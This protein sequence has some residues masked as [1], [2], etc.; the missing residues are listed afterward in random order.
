MVNIIR[1]SPFFAFLLLLILSTTTNTYAA[2]GAI[3]RTWDGSSSSKW[4][5]NNNWSGNNFPNS[6]AE[7]AIIVAA[8]RRP[9][10]NANI[11]VGCVEVQS[12]DMRSSNNRTFT[13]QGDYFRA[14]G[15]AS[16]FVSTNHNWTIHLAGSSHQDLDIVDPV[17]NLTI[18]NST[19]VSFN[20]PF[21]VRNTFTMSGTGTYLNVNEDLTL[22]DSA[23]TVTIPSA[24]TIEVA[25]GKTLNIFGSLVVNGTLILNPG[26]TLML[27]NAKSLTVGASGQLR[28]QGSSGNV[29]TVKSQ[30]GSIDAVLNGSLWA[31]YFRFSSF[32]LTTAGIKING[33][34]AMLEFGEFHFIPSGGY[35]LTLGSTVN[36][37]TTANGI[38]FYDDNAYG[39]TKSINASSY[40]STAMM[41]NDWSGNGGTPS[42]TDPN[43]KIDWGVQ[44]GTTLTLSN[45][46]NIGFPSDPVTAGSAAQEFAIFAFALSQNSA[47]TDITQVTFTLN[48][49]ATASDIDYVQVFNQGASCQVRGAQIGG[50]INMSGFPATATINIPSATVTTSGTTPACIHVLVRTTATAENNATIGIKIDGTS[51]VVNSQ[52]Y[53][54]SGVSGPPVSGPVVTISGDPTRLWRGSNSTN[55]RTNGNWQGGWPGF[56]EN[57]KIQAGV[58]TVRL[59]ANEACQNTTLVSTGEINWNNSSFSLTVWGYL[60]VEAGFTYTNAANSSLIMGGATNQSMV[61]SEPFPGNVTINNT[62]GITS[63]ISVDGDSTI[64]GNLTVTNGLLRIASGVTLQVNGSVTVQTG[65]KLDIEPGGTL[66]MANGRVVTINTG[67]TLEMV[68]GATDAIM[69]STGGTAAF[70]VVVNGTIKASHYLFDHLGV[71]GVTINAG[72]AIDATD[73]LSF[74]TFKHPVNNSSTLLTLNLQ[75]PGNTLSTMAFDLNGSAA[76]AATI[77]NIKT[78]TTVG[79]LTI[80]SYSGNLSGPTYENAPVYLINWTGLTN[81]LDIAQ[82]ATSST[83]VYQGQTYNMGRFSL[84]QSQAGASYVNTNINSIA[85]TLTG[86]G[87]SNDISVARLYYD[88]NCD[89]SG[90]VLKGTGTFAGN[91]AKVTFSGM[92]GTTIEAST[93][94]PPTRCFYV[95]YDISGSAVNDKTVGFS[96]AS[97]SDIVDSQSYVISGSTPLPITSGAPSTII[98]SSTVWTGAVNTNWATAGNWNGGVPTASL[99]CVINSTANQPTISA[100]TG[101]C[102]S[103]FQGAGSTITINTGTTLQLFGSLNNDGTIVANGTIDFTDNGINSTNQ[104]IKNGLTLGNLKLSKTAN[105]FVA[106]N[107]TV[108]ANALNLSTANSLL[109]LSSGRVLILPN[110][111]VLNSGKLR[112]DAAGVVKIGN[113]QSFTV[114][115][116]D[117]Q[118]NGTAEAYPQSLSNKAKMTVDGAGTWGLTGT[119][120]NIT[121]SGFNL[122][123]LNNNGLNLTGSVNLLAFTGGQFTN[124]PTAYASMSVMNINST[125]TIPALATN[126]GINWG[127][128]NAYPVPA[129]T[130]KL[131]S[132]TGCAS[133]SMDFDD[134]FGD[135]LDNATVGF[136][137]NSKVSQTGCNVTFSGA[138]T[139]V[140]VKNLRADAYNGAVDLRWD[141]TNETDHL[142]FHVFRSD[143]NGDHFIQLSPRM[144]RNFNTSGSLGGSYRFVDF[145]AENDTTYFYYIQD[146]DNLGISKMWGPV[147]ARPQNGLG[148]PPADG[149]SDNSGSRPDPTN[150]TPNP[151]PYPNGYEDLGDG[152][153]ILARSQDTIRLKIVPGALTTTNATWNASYKEI[154]IDGY[155]K[156]EEAGMPALLERTLLIEVSDYYSQVQQQ[157]LSSTQSTISGLLVSPAPQW[158]L[159]GSGVLIPSY[160]PNATAYASSLVNPS[161]FTHLHSE[162]ISQGAKKFI[163]IVISPTLYS[164]STKTITRLDEMVVDLFLGTSPWYEDTKNSSLYARDNTVHI[165]IDKTGMFE[166]N[167][168]D[169]TSAF[170]DGPVAGKP[171]SS[172]RVFQNEVEIPIEVISADSIFNAGDKIRFMGLFTPSQE[173]NESFVVLSAYD[174]LGTSQTPMRLSSFNVDGNPSLGSTST[175][176]A[177]A[178]ISAEENNIYVTDSPVGAEHDHFFWKMIFAP[179]PANVNYEKLPFSMTISGLDVDSNSDAILSVYLKGTTDEKGNINDLVH[180]LGLYANAAIDMVTHVEF[181]GGRYQKIN[182]SIPLEYLVDGANNFI[183]RALASQTPYSDRMQIDRVELTYPYI[184]Y[185]LNDQTILRNEYAN[186]KMSFSGLS[187]STVRIFDISNSEAPSELNNVLISGPDANSEYTASFYSNSGVN[188]ENGNNFLIIDNQLY[189]SVTS[190]KVNR[191]S[192]KGLRDTDWNK[193]MIVIGGEGALEA[194]EELTYRR[195]AQGLN[196][197][198]VT[199]QEI[200]NEFS[201][202]RASSFAIKEFLLNAYDTWSTRP[203]YVLILGDSTYDPKDHFGFGIRPDVSPM[204]VVSGQIYDFGSDNWF[205]TRLDAVTPLMAIGRFPSSDPSVLQTM[206]RKSLDFE[207]ELASPDFDTN[208]KITFLVDNSDNNERFRQRSDEISQMSA[209]SQA[210]IVPQTF[211]RGELGDAQMTSDIESSFSNQSLIVNYLGHGAEDLWTDNDLFTTAEAEVLSNTEYP[212]LM[213]LNCLN[214][215]FYD[216]DETW[217]SLGETL[218]SNKSGGAVAFIGS[219]AMTTPNA[220]AQ[221]AKNFYQLLGDRIKNGSK[222]TRLGDLFMLAKQQLPSEG[223]YS[224]VQNSYLLVGDPSMKF[225]EKL[226]FNIPASVVSSPAAAPTKSGGG[227]SAM[228]ADGG[229]TTGSGLLEIV[230]LILS[231]MIGVWLMRK[232]GLR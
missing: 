4:A 202:G 17:N 91:P 5:T 83:Q 99:N 123:Y 196:V 97:S 74:G 147:A 138:V 180:S 132:S 157:I 193:S 200:Y 92:T 82:Q 1:K 144:I 7:N 175:K 158:S 60:N 161:T 231:Y 198:K 229:P 63:I 86:T 98:G 128:I 115:G 107:G 10:A 71:N 61:I 221:F 133:H 136:D 36:M 218:L 141:T 189:Y 194:V 13:V 134:Y 120:G 38:G 204:P 169:L 94:V 42:E 154:A 90:G 163:K 57:C 170:V 129:D 73:N 122:D 226:F 103:V 214:N 212:I 117:L 88:D 230:S 30:S 197:L 182:F 201:F 131:A 49:T 108:T 195:E 26:S 65:A 31:Q 96:V 55:W 58:R 2:C 166:L 80:N 6:S 22:S 28:L 190:L 50:N 222:S 213:A 75:V 44:A 104:V 54:F 15:V 111:A 45:N 155:S 228:G 140:S 215:Y 69:S 76:S 219:T 174:L 114:A 205:V 85:L 16:L 112:I 142:G 9:K 211:D 172:L 232:T 185:K 77:K 70:T 89:S 18:S 95:E 137:V 149:G 66:K 188:A 101:I 203:S 186:T 93:G 39:N 79:T 165:G 150:P 53:D 19:S 110:G 52:G 12:G 156:K 127:P 32:N 153:T 192:I 216:P 35:A 11:V 43:S 177:F 151:S 130:Y 167:Y 210:N 143:E 146:F 121:L 21:E 47:P 217:F 20:Y 14:T 51:D 119:S 84:K 102:N 64:N 183:L 209:L 199:Y 8:T 178:T 27:G 207:D 160:S 46:S 124:L 225:P 181:V 224:D 184:R 34:V 152:F 118:F 125:G 59:T 162:L 105:G 67:G 206:V 208:R 220:Q 37:P 145:S 126:V 139:A 23:Q 68:G 176:Q 148:T 179:Y 24:A 191:G 72:A 78:N 3:D 113:G 33:S 171:I 25:T 135:W 41:L 187:T 164:A 173:N 29:A 227:C 223:Y 40:N 109:I 62:G 168:S 87:S 100:G 159:D 116:G 106:F 81:T 56:N 48:G